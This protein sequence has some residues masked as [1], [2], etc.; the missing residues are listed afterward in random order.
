MLDAGGEVFDTLR[1]VFEA[2]AAWIIW[3]PLGG[4]S[5]AIVQFL[6]V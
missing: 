4:K 5:G 6:N 1:L 2:G 3:S